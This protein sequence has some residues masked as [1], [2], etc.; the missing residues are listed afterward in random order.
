MV[1]A[2][3]VH[4]LAEEFVELVGLGLVTGEAG[5]DTVSDGVVVVTILP[6][7]GHILRSEG[8]PAVV[9]PVALALK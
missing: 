8:F 4:L 5:H 7:H 1:K 9:T 6:I 2:S 3:G